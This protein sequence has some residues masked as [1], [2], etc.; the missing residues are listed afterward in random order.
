[1]EKFNR[2]DFLRGGIAAAAV[3]TMPSN[4][5]AESFDY[6]PNKEVPLNLE[7]AKSALDNLLH[8]SATGLLTDKTIAIESVN[9]TEIIIQHGAERIIAVDVQ[10]RYKDY[11]QGQERFQYELIR[12]IIMLTLIEHCLLTYNGLSG[13]DCVIA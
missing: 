3:S 6:V 5:H 8:D 9:G 2:R 10:D 12:G 7:T 1:M 13:E 11:E 4:L